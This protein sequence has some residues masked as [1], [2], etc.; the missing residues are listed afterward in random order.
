[1]MRIKITAIHAHSRGKVY[2]IDIEGKAISILLTFHALER[3]QKWRLSDSV[4]LET[5]LLPEEVL[6][7]HRGRFIAHRRAEEHI[8]RVVYEY[9]AIMPSVVTV[10][11]PLASRYF[12][13]GSIHEDQIL[14]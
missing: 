12:Q 11:Y 3:M 4:V 6:R 2:E 10:Y 9:E 5:L 14:S 8:I 1:M 7:G 13:G